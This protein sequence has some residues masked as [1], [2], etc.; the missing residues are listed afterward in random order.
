MFIHTTRSY[1]G[2][3]INKH[4]VYPIKEK[5]DSI[6]NARIPQNV[7]ELK[8]FLGRL[9]YYHRHFR[10][11]AEVLEPLHKLLRKDVKWEWGDEQNIAFQK[12]KNILCESSY[13]VHYEPKLLLY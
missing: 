8:S 4:G 13:L 10:N 9:N 3:K 2:F 11:F 6:K 5:I 12:A 1:L 7:S